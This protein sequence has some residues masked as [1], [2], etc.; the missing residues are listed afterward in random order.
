MTKPPP[1]LR[2]RLPERNLDVL[3]A[4]AVLS[5]LLFHISRALGY[6][7]ELDPLGRA[8]VLLFFVHTSLVLMGSLERSG[9]R[10][11][12]VSEFYLRRAFRIYPLAIVTV[13][14]VVAVGIPQT[15]PVVH[16][17]V[18]YA[19]A[20]LFVVV[21]NLLLVQ[22]LAGVGNV[23]G[24]LW[25]LPLE[26]QM[27]VLLPL[28]FL[29]ARRG[30]R[31]IVAGIL[32]TVPLGLLLQRGSIPGI[33]RLSILQFIPCFLSGVLAYGILARGPKRARAA[34]ALWLPLLLA[35]IAVFFALAD[36]INFF[37]AE[38][39][40]CLGVASLIPLVDTLPESRLTRAAG[41]IA[42]YSYGIYLT[43]QIAFWV[44]FNVFSARSDAVQW[45]TTTALVVL[46]PFVAYHL[47]EKPF[48]E[49]GKRF[50][51]GK[52]IVASEAPAP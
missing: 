32:V 35:C 37:V 40:F 16:H 5:V 21:A 14:A 20:P 2:T 47:V 51:R 1:Q 43:H 13:L 34:A 18:A 3:R 19:P 45:L 44:G 41:T 27:Y 12:W 50:A 7:K 31:W 42:L 8:G 17:P 4:V 33:W 46:L 30:P 24:V 15:V 9:A 6:H 48:I 23:L 49:L 22:N 28:C 11:S 25:S 29:A 52:E 36:R 38:W 26:V 10:G 39:I